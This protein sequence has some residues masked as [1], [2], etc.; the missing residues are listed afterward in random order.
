MATRTSTRMFALLIG[1]AYLLS[2]F[3]GFIPREETR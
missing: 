2:G 1:A 3:A